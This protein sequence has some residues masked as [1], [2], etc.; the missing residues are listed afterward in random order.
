M[1]SPTF[2]TFYSG[3]YKGNWYLRYDSECTLEDIVEEIVRGKVKPKLECPA[4][5]L[6]RFKE[7]ATKHGPTIKNRYEYLDHTT[8]WFALDVDACGKYTA[9][10]K[11]TLFDKLPELKIVWVSSSGEGVKGI[12]FTDRLRGLTPDR[13]KAEYRLLSL[14]LR[15]KSK[16]KIN[17]DQAMGRCHQPVFLNSDKKALV[18]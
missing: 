6:N 13:F 17:F 10:V 3:T 18:R 12:G 9:V 7:V 2:H 14:R 11:Q 1:S 16:M 15:H 4:I 8:G 5:I